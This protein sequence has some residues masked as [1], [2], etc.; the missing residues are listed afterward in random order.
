[1]MDASLDTDIVVHLYK[2]GKKELLFSFCNKLYMHWYL[3][4]N[5]LK[6]K[7]YS[8]Y[9]EVVDDT[10]NGSIKI[11]TGLD[12][13][14]MGVKNLFNRYMEEYEF[15]FDTG[16][17]YAV[18]L[19]KTIG[20]A[21]LLSDDTKRFGPHDMLVRGLVEGVIPFAFYE[22]LFLKY[23][24]TDMTPEEMLYEFEEVNANSMEKHPMNFRNR[25]LKTVRRF[26]KRFGEERDRRGLS[27][28][29]CNNGID[30]GKKV[31]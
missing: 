6:G 21:A 3:L 11:V 29:C 24:K 9:Q 23:I 19:A 7:S 12:L 28:F 10:C 14:R 17:Q 5:E 22:L 2:S 4:E 20:I 27:E 26:S 15:L 1:M 8:V 25:M 31:F 30:Y 18:A 13:A 16:E